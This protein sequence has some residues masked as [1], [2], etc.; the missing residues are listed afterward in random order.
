MSVY[1]AGCMCPNS[2]PSVRLC[3]VPSIRNNED[4]R[5]APGLGLHTGLCRVP[6]EAPALSVYSKFAECLGLDRGERWG[7]QRISMYVACKFT[8]SSNV[9][10]RGRAERRFGVPPLAPDPSGRQYCG[11]KD[12]TKAKVSVRGAP[13]PHQHQ[14]DGRCLPLIRRSPLRPQNLRCCKGPLHP[15]Y[16][17]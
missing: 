12:R 5:K 14:H 13:S 4:I 15:K 2:L 6:R 10:A 11:H 9:V 3:R 17:A 16:N 8:V 1:N 7:V